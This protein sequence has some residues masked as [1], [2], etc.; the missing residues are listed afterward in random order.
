MEEK[1]GPDKKM[2]T[3]DEWLEQNIRDNRVA[4]D[5]S[6]KLGLGIYD[7]LVKE[8]TDQNTKLDAL[9]RDGAKIVKAFPNLNM[10]IVEVPGKLGESGSTIKNY[11]LVDIDNQFISQ[12][13][14]SIR[15]QH[16]DL[17]WRA[18]YPNQAAALSAAKD[19]SKVL[20][21]SEVF[22]F[23]NQ[24]FKTGDIVVDQKGNKW[25]ISS[26]VAKVDADGYITIKAVDPNQNKGGKLF[27]RILAGEW[28]SK[29]WKKQAIQED[30]WD[31]DLIEGNV[32][33][34]SRREPLRF[35]TNPGYNQKNA[36]TKRIEK[37]IK[38][39]NT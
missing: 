15:L 19:I 26:N 23:D 20:P 21:S 25:Y 8:V 2:L 1:V 33:K 10:Y 37:N 14:P 4:R 27:S 16:S 22:T 29:K 13:F 18:S 7:I 32:S 28:V 38:F 31:F 35:W 6:D 11:Q 3:F 12:K 39:T 17:N 34:L 30:R 5:I 24:D 36:F 9:E